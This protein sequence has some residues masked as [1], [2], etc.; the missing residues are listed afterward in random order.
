MGDQY[1]IAKKPTLGS[2]WCLAT[3]AEDDNMRFHWHGD[4]YETKEGDSSRS[5]LIDRSN[6]A[7]PHSL[8]TDLQ[9]EDRYIVSNAESLYVS[10]WRAQATTTTRHCSGAS[11]PSVVILHGFGSHSMRFDFLAR[12]IAST[13]RDVFAMDQRGHGRSSGKRARIESLG[14]ALSDIDAL[15]DLVSTSSKAPLIVGHSMGGA[16]ALAYALAHPGK[17]S[18][19][20]LVSPA[21]HLSAQPS[22]LVGSARA[23]ACICPGCGIAKVRPRLLSNELSVRRG[24]LEDELCWHGLVPVVSALS[25]HEAAEFAFANAGK[26]DIPVLIIHG[27]ADRIVPMESSKRLFEALPSGTGQELVEIDDGPHE[28]CHGSTQGQVTKELTRWI[29]ER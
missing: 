23:L 10:H 4:H 16:F 17:A 1:Y 28:L 12:V 26:L 9:R 11:H 24:F 19:L 20:A 21:V 2:N 6:T 14:Q 25:M 13:S 22:W 29:A 8:G 5:E 18:A 27:G 7:W 3:G 15:V